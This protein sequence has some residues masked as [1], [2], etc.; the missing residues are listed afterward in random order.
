MSLYIRL[1]G[2]LIGITQVFLGFYQEQVVFV[3][4]EENSYL[5]LAG[6]KDQAA[7]VGH[8]QRMFHVQWVFSVRNYAGVSCEYRILTAR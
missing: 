6:I 8:L 7:Q 5:Q 3:R 4:E 2:F 1:L